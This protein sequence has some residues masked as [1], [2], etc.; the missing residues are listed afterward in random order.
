MVLEHIREKDFKKIEVNVN[1]ELYYLADEVSEY[2]ATDTTGLIP[3]EDGKKVFIRHQTQDRYPG[4][5][6]THS[7]KIT[8]EKIEN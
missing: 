7:Y 5:I 4:E 3:S 1:D 6:D 8:I 2:F